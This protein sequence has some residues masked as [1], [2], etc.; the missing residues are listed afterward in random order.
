MFKWVCWLM[1]AY[2]AMCVGLQYNDPDPIRWMLIYGGAMIVSIALPLRP[3]VAPAGYLF[4]VVSAVW[5]GYLVWRIWGLVTLSDIP[6]HMSEKGGAVEEERE[7]GGLIIEAVW[8]AAASR[9]A[10]FRDRRRRRTPA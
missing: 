6:R 2:F 10:G 1:A 4:A 7:A 3:N 5:G 9:Y 8:L